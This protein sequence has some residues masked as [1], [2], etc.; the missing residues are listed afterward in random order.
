[1]DPWNLN[2]C[3]GTWPLTHE[4]DCLPFEQEKL[5][6]RAIVLLCAEC[7]VAGCTVGWKP[8]LEPSP[9]L[10]QWI[11][12]VVPRPVT[13]HHWWGFASLPRWVLIHTPPS[14][15]GWGKNY[16][17]EFFLILPEQL[18]LWRAETWQGGACLCPSIWEM[19]AGRAWVRDYT[20]RRASGLSKEEDRSPW[21]T[22]V[23]AKLSSADM[24]RK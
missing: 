11:Q 10:D 8:A 16:I 4:K 23:L 21:R 6:Y 18:L 12:T 2:S 7:H 20:V 9:N 24:V 3:K 5:F 15:L 17:T 22:D 14:S 1:M 13:G 19:E